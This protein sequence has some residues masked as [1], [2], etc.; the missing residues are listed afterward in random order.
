MKETRHHR[1][2]TSCPTMPLNILTKISG[3]QDIS[4]A[5]PQSKVAQEI[6]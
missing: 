5:H 3:G 2:F 1:L 4:L 6:V